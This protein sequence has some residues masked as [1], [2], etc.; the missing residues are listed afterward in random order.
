MKSSCQHVKRFNVSPQSFID[1]FNS[2]VDSYKF[3]ENLTKLIFKE[4]Q[5]LS[6][7]LLLVNS[8]QYFS[9]I[10]KRNNWPFA[11]LDLIKKVLKNENF[12]PA[13]TTFPKNEEEL[14]SS[15][16]KLVDGSICSTM[17]YESSFKKPSSIM[18]S[19][20]SHDNNIDKWASCKADESIKINYKNLF[21][22]LGSFLKISPNI[23]IHDQ[24]LIPFRNKNYHNVFEVFKFIATGNMEKEV[25]INRS[26]CES[27]RD[28]KQVVLTNAS[29][30]KKEA[31][32]YS[33]YFSDKL[34]GVSNLK[35]KVKFWNRLH[36]RYI[37][38]NHAGFSLGLG[39]CEEQGED[40][41][42]CTPMSRKLHSTICTH[43]PTSGKNSRKKTLSGG[44]WEVFPSVRQTMN[45]Q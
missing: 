15:N 2:N 24:Y 19:K 27:E 13:T 43:Y 29:Q 3:K 14:I 6:N 1:Q 37:F 40:E 16:Y 17:L 9:Q 35:I 42:C 8:E 7:F 45:Y 39:L 33:E 26:K 4:D 18:S 21:R 25:T 36:E 38:S 22:V 34:C 12:I 5:F 30:F 28:G 20:T 11:S 41:H 31:E 10:C 44:E 23:Q 32:M